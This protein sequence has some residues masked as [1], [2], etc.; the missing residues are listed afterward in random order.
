MNEKKKTAKKHM[1][2]KKQ[3]KHT[4]E[5]KKNIVTKT[6]I[7]ETNNGCMKTKENKHKDR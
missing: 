6:N 5:R 7:N 1:N 2:E 3:Q 4:D